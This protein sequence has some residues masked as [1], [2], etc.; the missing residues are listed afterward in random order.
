MMV[1]RTFLCPEC[2]RSYVHVKA[3]L[4]RS[5]NVIMFDATCEAGHR[6]RRETPVARRGDL[7]PLVRTGIPR[8]G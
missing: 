3:D 7:A 6:I 4:D 2:G 5:R 8:A 1:T